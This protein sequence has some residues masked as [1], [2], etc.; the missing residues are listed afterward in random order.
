MVRNWRQA[1]G[2]LLTG[3]NVFGNKLPKSVTMEVCVFSLIPV[4]FCYECAMYTH[5]LYILWC[6]YRTNY[7][8]I[9]IDDGCISGGIYYLHEQRHTRVVPIQ[10]ANAREL[11]YSTDVMKWYQKLN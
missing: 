3:S 10:N 2:S 5:N 11:H 1:S 6:F 4:R 9:N 8:K 7:H